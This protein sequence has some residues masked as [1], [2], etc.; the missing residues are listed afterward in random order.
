MKARITYRKKCIKKHKRTSFIAA[1]VVVLSIGLAV[2]SYRGHIQKENEKKIQEIA[3]ELQEEKEQ[4]QTIDVDLSLLQEKLEQMTEAVD[5]T[6][7]IYLKDLK[8]DT[9]FSINNQEMYA[10]SLIKLFVMESSYQY[11]D[12]LL[13]NENSYSGAEETAETI[14]KNQLAEMIEQSDNESYNDLVSLH[15]EAL[16]FEDGCYLVEEYLEEAGYQDTGI[17]HTLSPSETEPQSISDIKNHTSVEDC[18]KLLE[19]IYCGTCISKE[20]SQEMLELLM[21]QENVNKIPQGVPEDI[22]TANKTGETEEVQHDA[23]I[24]F[25]EKTDYILCVMST[26]I[27]ESGTAIQTIQEI[28]SVVYNFLNN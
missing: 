21:K 15:S 6:W 19:K 7:S 14:I 10:A 23:A 13:E 27:E 9:S 1:V 28:S 5:G 8:T 20:A 25:G 11:M 16:D 22:Q 24:V 12:M 3:Q 26:G 2:G 18:G 17:F 4:E